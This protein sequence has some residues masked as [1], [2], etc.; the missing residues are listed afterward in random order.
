MPLLLL[1]L[2]AIACLPES[3]PQPL[4]WFD[5]AKGNPLLFAALTGA[6]VL[7][8]AATAARL[9]RRTR[10]RLRLHPDWREGILHRHAVLRQYHFYGLCFSFLLA[11]YVLGWGWTVQKFCTPGATMLPGAE[12][13]I[14]VPLFLA[15]IFSWFFFYDVER[16]A[17]DSAAP[18]EALTPFWS[19]WT[20]IRFH[21]RQNLALLVLPLS[22]LLIEKGLRR[23]FPEVRGLPLISLGLL[24]AAFLS[25]PW[26]LRL[27]LGLKPLPPS[28][29]RDRLQAAARRLHF[30]HSD[31][32]LWNTHGAIANAMVAGLLPNLRYVFLSDR[33]V[34]ELTPAEVEAVLG[35][36]VGHV[37]H[38][39]MTLYLVFLIL[40]LTVMSGVWEMVRKAVFTDPQLRTHAAV[41]QIAQREAEPD[42]DQDW[43]TAFLPVKTDYRQ[44]LRIALDEMR[45]LPLLMF[46]G[47]Y[48]FVVFGFLSR[49][50]ERQADLFGCRAVSCGRKD[51]AGHDGEEALPADGKGLCP[52]GIRI[53][54][55]A[56]EKVARLNGI[57]R[58][59]PGWLQSWQH[60]TIASRVEFLQQVLADPAREPRFQRH[61]TLV[62]WGLLLFLFAALGVLGITQGWNWMEIS[63]IF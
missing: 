4:A 28:P 15:L 24:V 61:V 51:C 46:V 9:S 14:L 60:S 34:N 54:I 52:T 25:L 8:A 18:P 63:E 26:I 21:L 7:L 38:R 20:Y 50:C 1:L 3:W 62:K 48:V 30:R 5:V 33:L 39:H 31:I 57:S 44:E 55:A 49:R 13:L 37:K 22:L 45:M 40:S 47:V 6:E 58:S 41:V 2:L 32:L 35:H 29:L 17:H 43:N 16:A 42:Q 59:R 12:L 36:E 19:R 23:S 56:L 27:T 53:F 10:R 11:V